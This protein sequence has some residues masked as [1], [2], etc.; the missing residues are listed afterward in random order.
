MINAVYYFTEKEDFEPTLKSCFQNFDIVLDYEDNLSKLL[1][2]IVIYEPTI[3]FI[4]Y[5]S[6]ENKGFLLDLF[7]ENSTFFIPAVIVLGSDNQPHNFDNLDNTIF[8]NYKNI[9]SKISI[10]KDEIIKKKTYKDKNDL[11]PITKFNEI[12]SF[13]FKINFKIK[14][15]GTIYLK[16]CIKYCIIS[17]KCSA[18]TMSE[19]YQVVACM[20]NTNV[21]NIE[22]SI[23]LAIQS[24]WQT[25]ISKTVLQE[26]GLDPI[27]FESQ[28][29][30][31]E[32]IVFLSEY[33]IELSKER[34]LE[35]SLN[36]EKF[37]DKSIYKSINE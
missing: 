10:L 12:L 5:K 9:K 33:F 22:R 28:P 14:N 35:R 30:C 27:F 25:P 23:R 4:D 29:S 31:R 21:A 2:R 20:H 32:L 7:S 36:V 1:S 17:R 3:L 26:L 11:F 8:I 16:D 34:N 19:A 18:C 13:L 37:Y 6:I 15:Q 24:T